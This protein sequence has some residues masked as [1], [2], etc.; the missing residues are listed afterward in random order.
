MNHLHLELEKLKLEMLAMAKLVAM[1]VDKSVVALVTNNKDLAREV[2]FN[3]KRVNAYE[4]KIDKDCENIFA[5]FNPVAKDLRFVF[6]SLKSNANLERMG[7]NAEG[8]ARFVLDSEEMPSKMLLQEIGL[9]EM[10]DL[11]IEMINTVAHAYQHDDAT[12]ARSL[13]EKDIEIN[14]FNRASTKIIAQEIIANTHQAENLLQ[15]LSLIRKLERVGDLVTNMA[16]EI[17][18]IVEAKVLKHGKKAFH[19]PS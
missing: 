1:Q 6:A 7:D 3:E 9:I 15:F 11:C 10:K 17:V 8:I 5:L 14:Q 12:L 2:L 4:L 16:E 13:F 19:E 18:F